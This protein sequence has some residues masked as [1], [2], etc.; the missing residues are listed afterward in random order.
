[1]GPFKRLIWVRVTNLEPSGAPRD[2]AEGLVYL[3]EFKL[4]CIYIYIREKLKNQK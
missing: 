3:F 2:T 1:M 4:N